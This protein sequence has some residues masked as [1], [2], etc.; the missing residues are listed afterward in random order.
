MENADV[1]PMKGLTCIEASNLLVFKGV[2]EAGQT[3]G[4]WDVV[5]HTGVGGRWPGV[6]VQHNNRL[7]QIKG[8]LS[9]GKITA[10]G[11]PVK[12]PNGS[13]VTAWEVLERGETAPQHAQASLY[14]RS[15]KTIALD[16]ARRVVHNAKW[17]S[18]IDRMME[19]ATAAKKYADQTAASLRLASR[20]LKGRD[21]NE[22]ELA[23]RSIGAG[24]C[25]VAATGETL[26]L[27]T[28]GLTPTQ[29]EAIVATLRECG[30][31]PTASTK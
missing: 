27:H 30:A 26:S 11:H 7:F 29:F 8:A 5:G 21:A 19:K 18:V 1:T 13:Y 16:L 24:W 23:A 15:T 22:S 3:A 10:S 25:S 31:A 28:Y 4:L 20:V 14:A 12:R 9:Q 17:A 6:I 2:V